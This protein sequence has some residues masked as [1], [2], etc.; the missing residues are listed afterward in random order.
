MNRIKSIDALRGFAVI[1]VILVHTAQITD[2]NNF[3]ESLKNLILSGKSGVQMFY[4]ISAFTLF[5]S[6]SQRNEPTS[7]YFIRR[8]F[9]IAP[10]YWIA[11]LYYVLVQNNTDWI[12]IGLNISFLHGLSP[13]AIN[14]VVP[15]GWSIGVEMI[16]YLLVPLLF[17]YIKS[18]NIAIKAFNWSLLI[19]FLSIYLLKKLN[20]PINPDEMGSY[21]YFFIGNQLP[22]FF[23]G[24]ILFKFIFSSKSDGL[25]CRGGVIGFAFILLLS[26]VT[27]LPIFRNH[28]L[29]S[30]SFLILFAALLLNPIGLVVN[31]ITIYIGKISYSVYIVQYAALFI[32]NYWP[33]QF[34]HSG[35]DN[36]VV[37]VLKFSLAFLLLAGS[38]ILISSVTYRLIEIPGQNIGKW[39]IKKCVI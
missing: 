13:T 21:I 17:R 19:S 32:I 37:S 11:I 38:S 8:F 28:I 39:L 23:I 30:F 4:I 16:F 1:L 36:M 31:K 18:L 33:A 24:F 29:I 14:S 35:Y 12:S 26:I 5:F 20:L 22:V 3:P 2:I 25:S 27:G 34:F 6:I 7:A 9:R 15:G 10:L